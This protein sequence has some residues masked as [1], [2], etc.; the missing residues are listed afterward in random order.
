[1]QARMFV[2]QEA[3]ERWLTNG[4]GA[5]EGDTFTLDGFAFEAEPAVRFVAEVA[6]GPDEHALLGRVKSRTQLAPLGAEHS[7]EAVVLGD[8]A[9]HVIEGF[10]L[11]PRNE[12]ARDLYPE[13]IELFAQP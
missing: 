10:A 11:S 12:G 4:R 1:M 2:P 3:L 7:P 5:L 8:N 9:Y 13:L 6:G